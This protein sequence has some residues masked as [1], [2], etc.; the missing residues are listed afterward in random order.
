MSIDELAEHLGVP[1]KTIYDRR[2]TG[3]GPVGIRVGRHLRFAVSDV[4]ALGVRSERRASGAVEPLVELNRAMVA[5]ATSAGTPISLPSGGGGV[6]G[7]GETFQPN[8]STSSPE[9]QHIEDPMLAEIRRGRPVL[10]GA[11]SGS[12]RGRCLRSSGFGR[13]G[14]SFDERSRRP[15]HERGSGVRIPSAPPNAQVRAVAAV[16][17]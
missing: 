16:L 1:I 2:Q 4:R 14:P 9:S 8:L 15:I 12:I 7:I 17:M 11:G 3:P 5:H 10:S 13:D 6:R